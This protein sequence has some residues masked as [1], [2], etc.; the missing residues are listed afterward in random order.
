VA[1]LLAAPCTLLQILSSLEK[2]RKGSD[3]AA[4]PTALVVVPRL[5]DTDRRRGRG[6]E[7]RLRLRPKEETREPPRTHE[8]ITHRGNVVLL[9]L[10]LHEHRLTHQVPERDTQDAREFPEHV[11]PGR[12]PAPGLG[13]REPVSATTYQP[14]QHL[15]RV[16]AALPIER[17]SFA[18]AEVISK[19]THGVLPP[20]AE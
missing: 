16:S 19:T 9:P 3:H 1:V 14:G 8:G 4:E 17:D 11:D 7:L 2:G 18:D 10:V 6:R 15:L 5:L 12:L 20:A 13:F